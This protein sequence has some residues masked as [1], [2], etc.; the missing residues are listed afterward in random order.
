MATNRRVRSHRL[1]LPEK[2][3]AFFGGAALSLCAIWVMGMFAWVVARRIA[4]PY[5]LEWMESGMLCHALRLYEGQPI[6]AA[7]SVD[8]IPHLYT[9]LYPAVVALLARV[10]GDVGYLLGRAVSVAAF[11]GSLLIGGL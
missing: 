4:Y 5:D 2:P 7:P 11:A 6:Y 10:T 9:P 1:R 3:V 8:F